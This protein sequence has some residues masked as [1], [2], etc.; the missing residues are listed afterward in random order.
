M[1]SHN[2]GPWQT[3]SSKNQCPTTPGLWRHKWRPIVFCFLVDDFGVEY[4]GEHHALRLKT[5]LG[6]HYEITENWKGNLYSGINL[7]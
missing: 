2:Q 6:D 1:V 7:Q 3:F 5:V 4:D